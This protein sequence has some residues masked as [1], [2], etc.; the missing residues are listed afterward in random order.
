L[1]PPVRRR[2]IFLKSDNKLSSFSPPIFF[3][4]SASLLFLVRVP[5][6]VMMG[7]LKDI[8]RRWRMKSRLEEHE[9]VCLHVKLFL[10][11]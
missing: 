11:D 8:G 9:D 2:F 7:W 3:L 4:R 10:L 1:L 6:V 5:C